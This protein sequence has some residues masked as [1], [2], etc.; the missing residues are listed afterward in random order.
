MLQGEKTMKRNLAIVLIPICIL[1]FASATANAAFYVWTLSK[2]AVDP[3]IN[4][5]L[6]T[7]G[8]DTLYLWF[9]CSTE[10]MASAE[11]YVNST[12]PGQVI[13][14]NV[15]N[16]YLNAGSATHLLLAV[17]GCPS[18]P[19]VS[20]AALILHVAPLAVC[21][22]GANVTVDCSANPQAW[23][24][25]HKGYVD[26]SLPLCLSESAALCDYISV[27][28]NSWGTIKSLYR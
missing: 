6:P 9:W 17:G 25:E 11:M 1:G 2:S 7:G 10:G 24:H 27:E 4:T 18:G 5:G 21:L 14:F 16:G 28:K 3:L 8:I 20:G 22:E 12:P 23:P 13:A 15:S 19:V 26:L